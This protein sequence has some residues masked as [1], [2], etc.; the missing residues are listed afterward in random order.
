M[1][2]IDA[3][4]QLKAGMYTTF[5]AIEEIIDITSHEVPEYPARPYATGVC[6]GHDYESMLEQYQQEKKAWQIADRQRTKQL[7]EVMLYAANCPAGFEK[8]VWQKAWSKGSSY[9]M[10]EVFR[11]LCELVDLLNEIKEEQ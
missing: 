1:T 2:Y 10:F 4:N 8:A 11:Q 7:K 3:Y 6:S 5:S 9:G